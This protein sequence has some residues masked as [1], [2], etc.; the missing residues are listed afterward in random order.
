[1]ERK[2]NLCRNCGSSWV[3]LFEGD[4][5]LVD[6]RNL[7]WRVNCRCGVAAENGGYFDTRE[8][9]IE[10]WNRSQFSTPLGVGDDQ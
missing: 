2:L 3:Y 8:A 4:T 10:E 1:M 5:P 7:G 9:A 6:Y